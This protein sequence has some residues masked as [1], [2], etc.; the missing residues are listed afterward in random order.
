M[1]NFRSGHLVPGGDFECEECQGVG[2]EGGVVQIPEHWLGECEVLDRFWGAVGSRLGGCYRSRG[3][4][5][6]EVLKKRMMGGIG[7][8]WLT[9]GWALAIWVGLAG[10]WQAVFEEG[11]QMSKEEKMARWEGLL[12]DL[13]SGWQKEWGSQGGHHWKLVEMI[14]ERSEGRIQ[15]EGG[16][17]VFGRVGVG[18][19]EWVGVG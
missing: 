4:G 12:V 16:E 9:L 6:W 2:Q 1:L 13:M 5:R 3:N 17:V 15:V 7:D 18:G 19:R 11:R 14:C 10:H 8:E